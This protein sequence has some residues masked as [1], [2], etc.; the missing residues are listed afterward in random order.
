[1]ASKKKSARRSAPPKGEPWGWSNCE[2]PEM[3]SGSGTREGAIAEGRA[4][5]NGAPF[6][7]ASGTWQKPT[8]FFPDADEILEIAAN[9]AAE[10]IGDP[11]EDWPPEPPKQ[12]K[13]ELD[14]F[15]QEWATKHAP[16]RFWMADGTKE[17]IDGK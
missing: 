9:R 2:D 16:C 17:E 8:Q 7:I 12:A 11:A 14:A 15:L 13:A 6:W 5:S 4:F 10:E 3:W 1:M